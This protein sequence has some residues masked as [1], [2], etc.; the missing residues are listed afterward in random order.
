MIARKSDG[1][2]GTKLTIDIAKLLNIVL[3]GLGVI[4][5]MITIWKFSAGDSIESLN[6]AV[7]SNNKLLNAHQINI[8]A[9]VKSIHKLDS[10]LTD[11]E[12]AA[13]EHIAANK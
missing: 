7:L 9:A 12:K 4:V 8:D 2:G 13:W 11:L 5:F 6:Q 3:A 10:Q 1:N